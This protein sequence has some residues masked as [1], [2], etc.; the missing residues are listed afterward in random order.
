MLCP[1]CKAE[2]EAGSIYCESCGEELQIVPDYDPLE[3]LVIGQEEEQ[4]LTSGEITEEQKQ[5]KSDQ[6]SNEIKKTAVKWWKSKL[7]G[8]LLLMFAAILIC[9]GIF[10]HS[11]RSMGRENDYSYQLE[12]GRELTEEERWEEALPYLK[13]AWSLQGNSEGADLKALRLMARA[14]AAIDAKEL[15]VG[16]MEDAV[17]YE[18]AVRGS[19]YDLREIYD[20]YM[21]IL[22]D[23]KQTALIDEVIEAC[24]YEDIRKDLLA[25][26]VEKPAC[27]M[28]EGTY[29]YYVMLELNAEYGSI[30]YTLDG[31][32]P[33][34]ESTRYEKPIEL[35]EGENLL[36]A[37]A[38]NKKGMVSEPLVRVYRL[39]FKYDPNM[40]EED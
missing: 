1:H 11:Y 13:Q 14:Y 9:F 8:Q 38:I 36:C 33:T 7:V 10:L 19:N 39:E 12:K 32:E 28:A 27:D 4:D 3:E 29:N 25:Y 40:D 18:S 23:T 15:A 20:E 5:K 6:E 34:K 35:A 17:R 2:L 16:C 24:E 30:Y 31:T 37:V 26:R 21:E 22:N